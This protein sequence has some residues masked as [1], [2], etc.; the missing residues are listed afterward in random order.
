MRSVTFNSP[1]SVS[2]TLLLLKRVAPGW[3]EPDF[4]TALRDGECFGCVISVMGADITLDL[5][6]QT[7][8]PAYV[9]RGRVVASAVTGSEIILKPREKTWTSVSTIA[10]AALFLGWWVFKEAREF[11]HRSAMIAFG[12]VSIVAFLGLARS[13][14][15]RRQKEKVLAILKY[16]LNENPASAT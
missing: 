12:V 10:L 1:H 11:G 16:I 3:R 9:W 13:I 7:Q 5:Q 6:P 2:D 15:H 4:P 14:G 8:I